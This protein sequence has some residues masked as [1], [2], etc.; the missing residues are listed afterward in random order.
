MI[1]GSTYHYNLSNIGGT[2]TPQLQS[3]SYGGPAPS[4]MPSFA[5]SYI[6]VL[7]D[8]SHIKVLTSQLYQG[9]SYISDSLK[10]IIFKDLKHVGI[11]NGTLL[12]SNS[13]FDFQSFDGVI[14]HRLLD[15]STNNRSY[16]IKQNIYLYDTYNKDEVDL[17]GL[18]FDNPPIIEG[19]VSG[20]AGF[21]RRLTVTKVKIGSSI[22][23]TQQISANL[24]STVIEGIDNLTTVGST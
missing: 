15:Y 17:R 13:H 22:T 18:T 3:L 11:Y 12:N 10:P 9:Y 4:I 14:F 20:I 21:A 24:G 2:S 6:K 5:G 1:D 23:D 19:T 7:P 16:Y 8:L